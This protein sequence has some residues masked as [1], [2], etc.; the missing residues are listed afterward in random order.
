MMSMFETIAKENKERPVSFLHSA[1]TRAH[2]AFNTRIEELANTL[3][4]ASADVLYSEE[5]DGFITKDFLAEK[6]LAGIDIYVC[7]PTPF[8]QVVINYL[9]ELGHPVEKV[10][11]EFFGPKAELEL[12][13]A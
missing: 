12:V 4:N 10:H 5:G 11:F 3:P 7:G 9:Y 8:M 1:R 13:L 6:V 2:Q